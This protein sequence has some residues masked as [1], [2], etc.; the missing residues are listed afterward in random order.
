M[1]QIHFRTAGI[2]GALLLLACGPPPPSPYPFTKELDCG[3]ITISIDSH[4]R[5]D[6]N[7]KAKQSD[8]CPCKEFGWTQHRSNA[9]QDVWHYDNFVQQ[10]PSGKVGAKSDPSKAN[11]PTTPPSGTEL[12]DWD[13]NPWYGASSDPK[14][15]KDFGEHPIPQTHISD[16]PDHPNTKF[17]TQ[18]VCV[19][20]GQVFLT[21]EWG[22]FKSGSEAIDKVPG[23]SV[24]PP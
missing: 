19:S 3:T 2:I 22:P 10:G 16:G 1:K 23:K 20:T 21:W 11:Q 15:P 8:K 13:G 4:G 7:F 12:K 14:T 24:T 6:F 18:L 17:M 9:D 5:I